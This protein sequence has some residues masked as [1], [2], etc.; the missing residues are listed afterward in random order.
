MTGRCSARLCPC[1]MQLLHRLLPPVP[2][3]EGADEELIGQDCHLDPTG[4]RF[5]EKTADDEAGDR[6]AV[7]LSSHTPPG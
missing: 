4:F 5:V 3:R 6:R 2:T 7:M 1:V